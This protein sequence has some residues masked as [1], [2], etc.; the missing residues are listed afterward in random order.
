ML[1]FLANIKPVEGKGFI[2]NR[3]ITFELSGRR[4]KNLRIAWPPPWHLIVSALVS[5]LALVF[6]HLS[7]QSY[8]ETSP[9][10]SLALVILIP[11]Y[12]LT[13]TLFP[14]KKDISLRRR[15]LLSVSFAALLAIL[16]GLI[17]NLTPRGLQPAS[18]ATVLSLLALFLAAVSY[19]RWSELPRRNRFSLTSKSDLRS[20]EDASPARQNLALRGMAFLCFL[21]CSLSV[22]LL[23]SLLLLI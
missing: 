20:S 23:P 21:G 19:V 18:L 9:L 15:A 7:P 17:L 10:M 1:A 13:L 3:S 5:V 16:F 11:G 14:S 8:Q 2:S 22:S 4:I 6:V 12:L